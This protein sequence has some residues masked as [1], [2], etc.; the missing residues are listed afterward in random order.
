MA[1]RRLDDV[2][3]LLFDLGGVVLEVD[4]GR[5]FRLW[6]QR[7]GCDASELRDR[8]AFDHAYGAYECGQARQRTGSMQ[9]TSRRTG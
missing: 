6:A 7:A 2:R 5:A 9:S 3:A 4:F 1:P 8:F